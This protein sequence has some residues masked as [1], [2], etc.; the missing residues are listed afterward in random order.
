MET[1][2]EAFSQSPR[3]SPRFVFP[4]SAGGCSS[5]GTR[6]FKYLDNKVK[7]MALPGGQ[8][9]EAGASFGVACFLYLDL[10]G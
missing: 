4:S 9:G 2:E 7:Q 6:T 8:S 1:G 10:R 3:H 5:G